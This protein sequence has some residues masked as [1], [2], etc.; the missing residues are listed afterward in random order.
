MPAQVI[1]L[2]RVFTFDASQALGIAAEQDLLT[3]ELQRDMVQAVMRRLEA[4]GNQ[5]PAH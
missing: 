5:R 1:E 3:Q 2:T 4:L